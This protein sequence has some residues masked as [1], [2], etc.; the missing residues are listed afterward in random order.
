MQIGILVMQIGI[1]ALQ[2]DILVMHVS[3]ENLSILVM[4]ISAF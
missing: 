3:N 4:Q 1:L 2:I